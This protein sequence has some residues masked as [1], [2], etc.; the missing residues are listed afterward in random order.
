M[1]LQ[2]RNL[3]WHG[4]PPMVQIHDETALLD[5]EHEEL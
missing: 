1:F 3:D 2:L 5:E 4:L